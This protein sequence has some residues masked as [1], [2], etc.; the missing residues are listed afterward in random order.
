MS[1]G[2]ASPSLADPPSCLLLM[3]PCRPSGTALLSLFALASPAAA[4]LPDVAIVAAAT[5][6]FTNCRY[7]DVQAFLQ[8]SGQFASVD[9]I[10]CVTTTPALADL[11]P[12]EAVLTWSNTNYL[13]PVA[14][15]D[16]LADYSDAGGAVV[17]TVFANTTTGSLRYLQGRWVTGGYEI[18]QAAQGNTSDSASLGSTLVPGHPIMAGVTALSAASAFRPLVSTPVL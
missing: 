15:G 16:L 1:Q 10:D 18:I 4:Q 7:T 17:V 5:S 3:R 2:A 14:L 11:A 6:S 8:A 12:Y 13:D 9:V